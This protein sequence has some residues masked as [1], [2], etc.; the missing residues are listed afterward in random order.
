MA[1]PL[2]TA[3]AW[4]GGCEGLLAARCSSSSPHGAGSS[5][6]E[7]FWPVIKALAPALSRGRAR[8][9]GD[10]RVSDAGHVSGA[11]RVSGAG[12]PAAPS[13]SAEPTVRDPTSFPSGVV[14]TGGF[15]SRPSP[16]AFTT[17]LRASGR[18]SPFRPAPRELLPSDQFSTSSCS[19]GIGLQP[20]GSG[21]PAV[22]RAL[23]GVTILLVSSWS[24]GFRSPVLGTSTGISF[25]PLRSSRC[26]PGGLWSSAVRVVAWRGTRQGLHHAVASLPPEIQP[27]VTPAV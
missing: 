10:E 3:M 24:C 11:R 20:H 27:L 6:F 1:L 21:L 25:P 26:W 7:T 2:L 8:L 23:L 19:S 9:C 13:P 22:S 18:R 17:G 12:A 5:D 4:T 14:I 15:C 16:F